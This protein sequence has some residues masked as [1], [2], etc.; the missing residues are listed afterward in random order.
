MAT[1]EEL[2]ALVQNLQ[3]QLN[4]L[5]IRQQQQENLPHPAAYTHILPP[6][7]YEP[8]L[9]AWCSP[10]KPKDKTFAALFALLKEHY[11][12]DKN[13]MLARI[14]LS[15][16]KQA[17]DELVPDFIR[18][19]T[20]L[21]MACKYSEEIS[22]IQ[23]I[24]K[25]FR[26]NELRLHLLRVENQ[27]TTLTEFK[28]VVEAFLTYQTTVQESQP[29][30]LTLHQAQACPPCPSCGKPHLRA[31]CRFLKEECHKCHK[32]GHIASVCRSR[33]QQPNNRGRYNSRNRGDRRRSRNPAQR[34][35]QIEEDE[36][37][38]PSYVPDTLNTL[39]LDAAN[40]LTKEG[41][42]TA[43]VDVSNG[44]RSLHVITEE[45]PLSPIATH[46]TFKC[47]Q[48]FA[49]KCYDVMSSLNSSMLGT[50]LRNPSATLTACFRAFFTEL[51][52]RNVES[53]L[54]QASQLRGLPASGTG[55]GSINTCYIPSS[56]T[57]AFQK[58][59]TLNF[60][61][62]DPQNGQTQPPF[63]S[64]VSSDGDCESANDTF[65]GL[66]GAFAR[67]NLG[68]DPETETFEDDIGD[69]T[70]INNT[71][72]T[73][74]GT[75]ETDTTIANLTDP[76]TKEID[77]E[78]PENS[79]TIST[80]TNILNPPKDTI[81]TETVLSPI[82]PEAVTSPTKA[83][84]KPKK[85]KNVHS[86][87]ITLHTV[88]RSSA[89]KTF[90]RIYDVWVKKNDA[91]YDKLTDELA[92][93]FKCHGTAITF[94]NLSLDRKHTSGEELDDFL[95]NLSKL[96][97]QA[98]GNVDGFNDTLCEKLVVTQF[99]DGLQEDMKSH[100]LRANPTT[101]LETMATAMRERNIQKEVKKKE[102]STTDAIVAALQ[103]LSVSNQSQP[104]TNDNDDG[105]NEVSQQQPAWSN[106]NINN[107]DSNG[108]NGYYDQQQR[109]GR[110]DNDFQNQQ[111]RDF[112]RHRNFDCQPDFPRRQEF[113]NNYQYDNFESVNNTRNFAN[114]NRYN[115][116]SDNRNF[117]GNSNQRDEGCILI[118]VSINAIEFL[119]RNIRIPILSPLRRSVLHNGTRSTRLRTNSST[120]FDRTPHGADLFSSPR[121]SANKS[122]QVLVQGARSMHR[123]L[124]I[125]PH[126]R[127]RRKMN[128]RASRNTHVPKR[129]RYGHGGWTTTDA[130]DSR[131][132][133]P[134]KQ[135]HDGPRILR[136]TMREEQTPS[137]RSRRS[138]P[139]NR[140]ASSFQP[141]GDTPLQRQTQ[142]MP[143][144]ECDPRLG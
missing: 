132:L 37:P 103:Q 72:N 2:Q 6:P 42:Y 85:Q 62:T 102:K 140:P 9:S 11:C 51:R 99:I 25:G 12:Q 40:P 34:T 114:N 54:K 39:Q 10:A 109:P 45:P 75:N 98:Y 95:K 124:V 59:P 126:G 18:R 117:C 63:A 35:H 15:S 136:Q 97:T 88:M 92:E 32:V 22:I 93:E 127:A 48:Q 57:S 143:K 139:D 83:L 21:A 94:R 125:L 60:S 14:Q 100:M 55:R 105:N 66:E 116:G 26:S 101:I 120:G 84:E 20:T 112:N 64:P 4:A 41:S 91:K 80:E 16:T 77:T 121:T 144:S 5:T 1:V 96:A 49:W 28:K 76:K 110:Y 65:N 13:P 111:R 142:R 38:E 17:S 137:H 79:T 36:P 56:A 50:S 82:N 61:E 108:N 138:G 134:G 106:N 90:N 71:I 53:G 69:D 119:L 30:T 81:E 131:P 70:F 67:V 141:D 58:N 86:R 128:H 47:Q 8:E 130:D 23:K 7:N 3:T 89:L 129:S 123:L 73:T 135:H 44:T 118:A 122:I 27:K 52:G 43:P 78:A 19:M 24:I 46:H 104:M 87:A 113:D 29:T 33:P 107:N 74:T 115:N 68:N 31:T 133:S